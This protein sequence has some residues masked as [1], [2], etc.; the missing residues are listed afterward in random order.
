MFFIFIFSILISKYL[1]IF[2]WLFTQRSLVC[3]LRC[4][5]SKI[6]NQH[7]LHL[8]MYIHQRNRKYLL[9]QDSPTQTLSGRWRPWWTWRT[10]WPRGTWPRR[11]RWPP[12]RPTS[13]LSS[14]CPS[15]PA[16]SWSSTPTST[17]TF[18]STSNFLTLFAVSVISRQTF[19]TYIQLYINY[20]YII[21][22]S[23]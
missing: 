13:K 23:I 14:R 10:A 16:T 17:K 9:R 18:R 3:N 12:A 19:S 11:F 4:N 8:S 2:L 22:L 5:A 1:L 15:S 21:C 7:V 6:L 20:P